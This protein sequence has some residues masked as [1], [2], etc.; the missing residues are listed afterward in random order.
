MP[1]LSFPPLKQRLAVKI[2]QVPCFVALLGTCGLIMAMNA[3]DPDLW[4]H[5]QYGRE[6]LQE[7]TLPNTATW[8]FTAEGHPWINHE[9]LAEL[10]MA[11]TVE[12]CGTLG[13]SLGKYLLSLL[14]IG[15]TFA[16]ARRRGTSLG[17]ITLTCVVMA[18]SLEFHWHFRPQ[19]LGY[20]LFALMAQ[21]LAVSAIREGSGTDGETVNG[22]G[23]PK[24][25]LWLIPLTAVWTNTH[26]SFAA[27]VCVIVACLGLRILERALQPSAGRRFEI[28][29]LS[30]VAV[31][32]V[33]STLLTPYGVQLPWWLLQDVSV[34]RPEIGDW[35][36]LSPFDGSR[37]SLCFWI[38]GLT[39]LLAARLD[40]RR[41]WIFLVVF[42]LVACQAV[43][44]I[45]HL[46]L[47]AILW[48]SWFPAS[49]DRAWRRLTI[50]LKS[51]FHG[52]SSKEVIPASADDAGW[53]NHWMTRAGLAVWIVF[54]AGA[55]WPRLA[56]IHVSR[57]RYPVDAFQF[58]ADH[59]LE[60][61]MIVS[62]NWAQ[63]AIGLFADEGL[64]STVAVDGRLRTCYPQEVIDIYL[65]FFLGDD[66]A[67]PRYRSPRSGPL[68]PALALSHAD[69]ELIL[70]S[71]K[72]Q[73]SV[74]VMERHQD[75]WTL[76]YQDELAQLWGRRELYDDPGRPRYLS[77]E[78]RRTSPLAVMGTRNWPAFP[79]TSRTASSPVDSTAR[80]QGTDPFSVLR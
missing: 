69:P 65:D 27:G 46:A 30:G 24:T 68:D 48:G 75:R 63:Y 25:L 62:F 41:D 40:R 49:I 36:H 15:M 31:L 47:L 5:V 80:E 13:L 58:L 6:I 70:I 64:N 17:V 71:R 22:R 57:E 55:T 14:L 12:T 10:V 59:R 53:V 34:P 32:V 20:V 19:V 42:A 8:T 72:Q 79:I 28:T 11:S 2:G 43:S 29:L 35:E 56:N 78:Q 61:R 50:D 60:G 52:N 66:P 51:R 67:L 74:R 38:M 54:V 4:G 76:L 7:G 1:L 23:S 45:R 39:T 9:I 33:L 18:L 44:H 16:M 73:P 77:V 26:G 3:A 21:I 37:E